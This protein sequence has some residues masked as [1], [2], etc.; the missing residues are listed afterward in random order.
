MAGSR[1]WGSPT[2]HRRQP[3]LPL[4]CSYYCC[5]CGCL[6]SAAAAPLTLAASKKQTISTALPV[7]QQHPPSPLVKPHTAG[8]SVE[9][10]LDFQALGLGRVTKTD[11][12][13]EA[14]WPRSLPHCACS[15]PVPAAQ[16]PLCPGTLDPSGQCLP[17]SNAQTITVSSVWPVGRFC[18]RLA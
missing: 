5:G 1:V 4:L 11:W 17:L 18:F 15:R 10:W 2:C 7:G 3:P 12:Q 8:W 14:A 9:G 16:P 13:G 6:G